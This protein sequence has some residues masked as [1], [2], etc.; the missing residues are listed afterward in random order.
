MY[1]AKGRMVMEHV[2]MVNEMWD[3]CPFVVG[4]FGVCV[5]RFLCSVNNELK[6]FY[7]D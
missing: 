3:F 5:C 6:T 4:F 2:S 7:E 1:E